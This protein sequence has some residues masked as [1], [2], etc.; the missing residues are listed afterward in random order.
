MSDIFCF[1][2]KYQASFIVIFTA[3]LALATIYLW[4]ATKQLWIATN[5]L[6]KK[7]T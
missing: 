1:L 5:R 7:T 6:L 2:E 3:V 4:R